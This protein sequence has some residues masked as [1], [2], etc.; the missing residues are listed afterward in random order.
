MKSKKKSRAKT[1]I[2]QIS[3]QLSDKALREHLL[4]FLERYIECEVAGK[5]LIVAHKADSKSPVK[6]DDITMHFSTIKSAVK[7]ASMDIDDN[8]LSRIF[9][10]EKTKGKKSAKHLRNNI[11]HRMPKGDIQEVHQ[12]YSQLMNDMGMFLNAVR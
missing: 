9:S 12:R 11:V 7:Y 5:E 6:Y 3:T 8:S 4:N 10:S 2:D 1:R